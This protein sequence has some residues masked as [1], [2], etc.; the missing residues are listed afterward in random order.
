MIRFFVV[1]CLGV[2]GVFASLS[3][4][5]QV[6]GFEQCQAGMITFCG[7]NPS[8]RCE[9]KINGAGGAAPCAG[10]GNVCLWRSTS[11]PAIPTSPAVQYPACNCAARPD[12]AGSEEQLVGTRAN[13]SRCNNGCLMVPKAI[14]GVPGGAPSMTMPIDGKTWGLAPGGWR[15]DG[16]QC[17]SAENDPTE[18]T[19]APD[20]LKCEGDSCITK[21]DYPEW[22]GTINGV[23]MCA[24][25]GQCEG[26]APAGYVCVGAPE[27]DAPLPPGPPDGPAAPPRTPDLEAQCTINGE[28]CEVRTWQ[29]PFGDAPCP[30]G[31][32]RNSAGDCVPD[33]GDPPPPRCPD[34][35]V[36]INGSCPAPYS[37][38]ADGTRPTGTPPRCY[39]PLACPDGSLPVRGQCPPVAGV[40]PGGTP[41]INGRCTAQYGTCPNGQPSVAGQCQPGY[42]NCPNGA[43]PVNGQCSSGVGCDPLTDPEQCTGNEDGHASGG[44]SCEGQPACSGDPVA[45][46]I[47]QMQWRHRCETK[48]A[49]TGDGDP[50]DPI[51]DMQA[52]GTFTWA[53]DETIPGGGLGTSNGFDDSGFGLSR[54]C[55]QVPP[56][57]V[58]GTTVEFP[59]VWCDLLAMMGTLLLIG[60]SWAATKI[61]ASA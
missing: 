45:C 3:A 16:A 31:Q 52:E 54:S 13:G 35:T 24:D 1:V 60:A 58:L 47:L 4:H 14:P 48:D 27:S 19:S 44:E 59:A 42:A 33:E 20:P 53:P 29:P 7:S 18:G 49:L 55:P 2:L 23:K 56:I 5:A 28:P 30:E 25:K 17:N 38:C 41:P 37:D 26:S 61:V 43:Q 51:E 8:Y 36:P 6:C 34:G 57:S 12:L 22:C 32:T 46:A 9:C 11:W 39:A 50:G 15:P 40:C 21:P 10:P